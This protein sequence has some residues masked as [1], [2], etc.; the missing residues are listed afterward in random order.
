[1]DESLFAFLVVGIDLDHDGKR[2]PEGSSVE[3]P[4]G[5][6]MK[7]RRWLELIDP[8]K[9]DEQ[10]SAPAAPESLEPPATQPAITPAFVSGPTG[11]ESVQPPSG[12]V[13]PPTDTP[14]KAPARARAVT[15]S[16]KDKGASK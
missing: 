14:P 9:A 10:S 2:Y 11:A 5:A 8:V 13:T 4:L 16:N 12:V 15:V 3:L 1:M 6:A 7:R